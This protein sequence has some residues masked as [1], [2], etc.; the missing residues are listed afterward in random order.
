MTKTLYI[1]LICIMYEVV[2]GRYQPKTWCYG[3]IFTPPVNLNPQIWGQP[4]RCNG[5]RVHQHALETAYQWLKH[6][7]SPYLG[8]LM[9]PYGFTTAR[10]RFFLFVLGPILYVAFV[11]VSTYV[12]CTK[13]LISKIFFLFAKA[14]PVFDKNSWKMKLVKSC[15]VFF[16]LSMY[17]K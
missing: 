11:S 6:F 2:W 4:G 14:A 12:R 15:E 17:N 5:I 10:H 7:V 1:Y 9:D 13:R 8:K 3:I 16:E